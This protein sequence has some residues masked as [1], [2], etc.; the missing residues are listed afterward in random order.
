[1]HDFLQRY[2]DPAD[3]LGEILFGLIM[4]LGFTGAVRL[5]HEAADNRALFIGIFGCNLAWAIVDGVMYVLT[6][7]FERGRKARLF[8]QVLHAPD[9]ETAL[10]RIGDELDGPLMDLTTP[11]ER[12]E[13]HRWILAIVRREKPET[14]KMRRGD[15]L[16]GVAV[17]LLIVLA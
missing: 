1:M 13:L 3:R 9:E 15:L 12:G 14:L 6:A 8:R 2:L 16:G 10:Q 11:E 5:G 7:L 17:A 4:A